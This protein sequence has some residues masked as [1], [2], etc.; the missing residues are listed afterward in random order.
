LGRAAPGSAFGAAGSLVIILV[1]VYYS[2]LLVFSGAEFTQVYAR[3]Y[4]GHVEP[5]KV[6]VHAKKRPPAAGVVPSSPGH[7]P[8]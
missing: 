6:A 4:G 3:L 1:W 5:E 8:G 7:R 2:S